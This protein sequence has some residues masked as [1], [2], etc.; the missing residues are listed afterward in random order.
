MDFYIYYVVYSVN[1]C[2]LVSIWAIFVSRQNL[3]IIF[4]LIEIMLLCLNLEFISL[5]LFF[6][7][8][9]GI[10]FFF[11]LLSLAGSEAS[12]SPSILIVIYRLR[13]LIS[14]YIFSFLKS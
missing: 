9:F 12:I 11:V 2:L 7:D 3:I 6:D 13:G 5:G 1:F 4:L 14:I 10:L 8:N